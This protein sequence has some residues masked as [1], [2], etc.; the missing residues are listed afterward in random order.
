MKAT[1]KINGKKAEIEIPELAQVPR[2]A[3]TKEQAAQALGV[4]LKTIWRLAAT[5]QIT[6]TSYGTYPIASLNSHLL[7]E[8]KKG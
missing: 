2:L 1:I 4:S 7:A 3:L 5:G 6:K 8:T